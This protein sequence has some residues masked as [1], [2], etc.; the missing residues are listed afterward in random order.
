MTTNPPAVGRCRYAEN[1]T[2]AVT[3][4][5]TAYRA[6]VPML[7]AEWA[8][9]YFYLSPESSGTEGRWKTLPYQI[10]L[11]NW[12]TSDDIEEVNWQKSRRVGYT[13]CLLA[14]A[15]CMIHQKRRNV[16]TWQP[17]DGDA[18][19]FSVDEVDTMLRD[20]P[21]LGEMLKCDP[22][23]K[24]KFNTVEKK[25]FNGATWDIKGGKS[26]RNFRRMSKDVAI[27][28][29]LSA[30]DPDIDGE[31]SALELGDGRLDQAPFP[32]SIRGSTPKIKGLC[33]IEAAVARA[34]K[35][36]TRFVRCPHCGEFQPLVFERLKWEHEDPATA[37]FICAANGCVL[38]Y[39]DYPIMDA[40][41]RWQAD[42]GTYYDDATDR[43][44]DA[45]GNHIEKP[46][47]IGAKIWAAYSYLRPWSWLVDK[48]LQATEESKTGKLTGLKAVVNTLLGETWEE[49]GEAVGIDQF[50]G[51]RL[52][53][54]TADCIPDDVLVITIGC[55]LQ[56]GKDS[57]LELEVVGWGVGEESWSIDYVIIPG[58]PDGDALWQHLDDQFRRTFEREDGI[59]LPVA[60]GMVDAG[61]LPSR[62][63]DFTRPREHRRIFSTKGKSQYSG[64]L[65]GKGSWQGEEGRKT[66]QF[67]INTDEGK[68]TLFNR[69]NKV[70]A[71]GPG[72]CHFPAHYRKEHFERLTNEEKR[73]KVQKGRII[74]HEWYKKG[75]N[76]PLDCRVLNMAALARVNPN[77]DRLKIELEKEAER[78]RLGLR[79]GNS[80][81]GRGR[82]VRSGG[83]A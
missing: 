16:A 21:I 63:H 46:R 76:E 48:W 55:D 17:T 7:G 83:I 70:L 2:L 10:A 33:Q 64:P 9:Q 13:K 58:D 3:A 82:R 66:L 59:I 8:D 73:Q 50:T 26:A 30:F 81:A 56:G 79:T 28:D 20:V 45:D 23:A 62:V 74:G 47:R 27:Y 35:V 65:L 78:L 61:Y 18:H 69:L 5:V 44:F 25:V 32:K 72:Y 1:I 24:N 37:H 43:F 49:K 38:Y 22:G 31:G 80:P 71:P 14:A 36:F 34:E 15:G 42:D 4:G 39:R 68:E 54:Y 40:A 51:D 75:P 60:G 19:D 11:I 67:P 52:D 6:D 12:M 29:E 41:G 57:R 53:D 77:F